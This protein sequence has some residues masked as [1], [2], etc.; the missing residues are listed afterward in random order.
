MRDFLQEACLTGAAAM[1][2]QAA[3]FP[4]DAERLNLLAG[5]LERFAALLRSGTAKPKLD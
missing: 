2:Y 5:T 4:D 1:R 3:D